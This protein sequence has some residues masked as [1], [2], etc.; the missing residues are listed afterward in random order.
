M[1]LE[2]YTIILY[3]SRNK[4]KYFTTCRK[5]RL[6]QLKGVSSCGTCGYSKNNVCLDFHHN[7]GKKEFIISRGYRADKMAYPLETIIME[8]DKCDVLC[9]N[10][11][12]EITVDQLKFE[13]FKKEIYEKTNIAKEKQSK[14]SRERIVN[15]YNKGIGVVQISRMLNCAKS[16]ISQALKNIRD[17]SST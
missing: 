13:K 14:V 7:T 3:E 4:W 8:M 1:F 11:H 2:Y 12:K 5:T 6:L 10:C 17:S 16:T 15:L 9:H